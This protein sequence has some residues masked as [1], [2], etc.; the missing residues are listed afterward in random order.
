MGAALLCWI[1]KETRGLT[2]TLVIHTV[3][4]LQMRQRKVLSRHA[5]LRTAALDIIY[6]R[7]RRSARQLFCAKYWTPVDEV[8]TAWLLRDRTHPSHGVVTISQPHELGRSTFA[9]QSAELLM[10]HRPSFSLSVSIAS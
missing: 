9:A 8:G 7:V 3:G 6:E 10:A 2:A 1:Q 5:T 4:L